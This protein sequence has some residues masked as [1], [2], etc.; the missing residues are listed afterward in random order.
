MT[1][2]VNVESKTTAVLIM[3][4]QNDI[5]NKQPEERQAILLEQADRLLRAARQAGYTIIHVKVCFRPGYPDVSPRNKLFS[6]IK[7]AGRLIEG[8][9]GSEIHEKVA[10]QPDDIVIVKRRVS[11]FSTTDLEAVLRSKNI[12]TLVLFGISTSGVVL[13]TVRWAADMDYSIV[14]VSD[15]CADV[16]EEV[17]RVLMEKVFPRQGTVVTC[18]DLMETITTCN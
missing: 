12:T 18:H 1:C 13:S 16:D 7:E 10:P 17:H 8:T 4:Y 3:D 15:A 9:P 2:Q 11:A 5:L 14:V 6:G